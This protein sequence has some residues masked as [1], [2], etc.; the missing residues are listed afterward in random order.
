MHRDA[1]NAIWGCEGEGKYKES[2]VSRLQNVPC[3]TWSF[4][5]SV[6]AMVPSLPVRVGVEV[7]A[8]G[9]LRGRT[10][11]GEGFPRQRMKNGKAAP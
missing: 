9:R 8:R 4:L 2:E 11:C 7:R 5:L 10:D 1:I 6:F 3:S